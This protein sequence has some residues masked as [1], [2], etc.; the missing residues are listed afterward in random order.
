MADRPEYKSKWTGQQVDDAVG[1]IIGNGVTPLTTGDIV[2]TTGTSPTKVMSQ[3]AVTNAINNIDPSEKIQEAIEEHNVDEQAHQYIQGLISNKPNA[4]NDRSD[5]QKD[6]YSANYI[7]NSFAPITFVSNLYASKVSD[8]TADLVNKAPALSADNVLISTATTNTDYN[9][10]SPD[11]IFTRDLEVST[12]LTA[13]NSF[14][15]NLTF[16][17]NRNATISW[18]A[19]I[20]VSQD[21]GQSW[22]YISDNQSYGAIS[23]E[24]GIGN[25][26]I[27]NV[28]TNAIQGTATYPIGTLLAIEIYKKQTSATAL[29]TTVYCGV[30][31]DNAGIYTYAQ[32]NFSNVNIGTNQLEDG[33]VTKQK[34]EQ[35]IQNT[36]DSVANK[37]DSYVGNQ[38][39]GAFTR[40]RR[41]GNNIEILSTD[42][43]V[44]NPKSSE[45]IV[46]QNSVSLNSNGNILQLDKDGLT[47]NGKNIEPDIDNES[48]TQNAQNQLQAVGVKYN[49]NLI[50]AEMIYNATHYIRYKEEP[51]GLYVDGVLSKTWAQLLSD[52][53]VTVSS[54]AL[55]VANT[56]LQG[57][58]V[59]D[60]VDGLT[61]LEQTFEQC[62]LLT[63]IDVSKLDTSNVTTLHR[64]FN[65]CPVLASL[66]LSNFNT[67]KVTNMGNMFSSC[68]ALA[69]LNLTSFNTSN[70]TDMRQMFYSCEALTSLDVYNFDTS[71]VTN[72]SGMFRACYG[73]ISIDLSNFDTSNVT[74]MSFMFHSC[75]SLMS[76]DVFR[77]ISFNT[78]NVTN[79]SYMF[80]GCSKLTSLDLSNFNTSNV[81]NMNSM[82]YFCDELISLDISNFTF[83]KV[84]NYTNMFA[85][86]P[87]NCE[88]L[89]KSQTEKDW[90]TSKFTNLTNVKI[91]G[92][93]TADNNIKDNLF[94]DN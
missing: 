17:I 69:S 82:F 66:N 27:F 77:F 87:D 92:A 94:G 59:C 39:T 76:L 63:S 7:N 35:S 4:L 30:E 38:A 5:S 55:K 88:I 40:I 26:A 72:M 6:T 8:N 14:A 1:K 24:T 3:A 57:D 37:V 45:I 74:D 58:L 80:R 48:I 64:T 53:D 21:N 36:L 20:K 65:N 22:T 29:T 68:K 12:T 54:G 49:D 93:S 51:A 46:A 89:V 15:L 19:K 91:K 11:F 44:P 85:N 50:T 16:I 28:F 60:N 81:T 75:K 70:V 41:S 42:A 56:S 10:A 32:F 84:T 13:Q 83:D 25:T 34:L 31:V 67:S 71:N 9:W 78:S 2:Q 86:V 23:Y 43:N 52:G 62:R 73:L 61:D 79:M 90:I 33:S 18:G 47:L